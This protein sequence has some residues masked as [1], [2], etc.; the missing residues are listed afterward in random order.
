MECLVATCKLN[1]IF[2]TNHVNNNCLVPNTPPYPFV[3]LGLLTM[4]GIHYGFF[5]C[6][7]LLLD[8]ISYELGFDFFTSRE[9][10]SKDWHQSLI[11]DVINF[12]KNKNHKTSFDLMSKLVLPFCVLGLNFYIA[13][14][15]I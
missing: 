12:I 14:P 5:F 13:T 10:A 2:T 11:L 15:N 9:F 1:K 7:N 8:S 6:N 4:L 3:E